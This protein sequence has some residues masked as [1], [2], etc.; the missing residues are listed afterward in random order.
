[1]QEVCADSSKKGGG[2]PSRPGA[3]PSAGS[4]RFVRAVG[5]PE[6]WKEFP[7]FSTRRVRRARGGMLAGVCGRYT[8]TA[9][10]ARVA[11]QFEVEVGAELRPRFNVAPGQDVAA[12]LVVPD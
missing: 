1:M 5:L 7:T 12:V 11:E 9:A 3:A 6:E 8:L 10:P 2:A 4:C